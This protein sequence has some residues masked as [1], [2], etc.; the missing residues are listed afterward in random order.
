MVASYVTD[1]ALGK[2][3]SIAVTAF[4]DGPSP[5]HLAMSIR[6]GFYASNYV[7]TTFS[8]DIDHAQKMG[9]AILAAVRGLLQET[10]NA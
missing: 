2:G 5:P 8:I 9:E 10:V 6:S 1:I 7:D 3:V 4:A